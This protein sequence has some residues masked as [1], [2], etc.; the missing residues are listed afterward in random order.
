MPDK[1]KVLTA[2]A[3]EGREPGCWVCGFC[4]PVC[5]L[6]VSSVASHLGVSAL[7]HKQLSRIPS[8]VLVKAILSAHVGLI[9][10]A[11]SSEHHGELDKPEIDSTEES[12]PF[13]A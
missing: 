4:V 13:A 9:H 1:I 2:H 12:R 11:A 3:A 5:N 8:V 7:H 10:R 6:G